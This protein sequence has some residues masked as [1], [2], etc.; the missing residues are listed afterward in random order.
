[1]LSVR[2]CAHRSHLVASRRGP[3]EGTESAG[4]AARMIMRFDISSRYGSNGSVVISGPDL[5]L[6][7]VGLG[8][9]GVDERRD[10]KRNWR[11]AA[12]QLSSTPRTRATA[13]SGLHTTNASPPA[14]S[15]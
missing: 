3:G 2:D 7:W 11:A 15:I 13:S 1:M 9:M 10:S 12:P 6:V 4:K 14:A 5:E 8:D